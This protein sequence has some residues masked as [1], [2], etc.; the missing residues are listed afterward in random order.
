[1]VFASLFSL[2]IQDPVLVFAVI[3]LVILFSPLL[4]NRLRVPGILGLILSGV[5]LGPH[6]LGVLER[7]ES[8]VLFS[9]IGLLYIMF[10]AGLEMDMDDFREN[11]NKSIVFGVLTFIIPL[12]LGWLGSYYVLGYS[13]LSSFLLASMFST[14]TLVAYPIIGRLGITQNK[15]V[16][17]ILGGTIITDAAVLI[18]LAVVTNLQKPDISSLF[19][20]QFVVSLVVFVFVVLWGVPRL[21]RWF[22]RQ[23]EGEGNSQY[24]FVL[25]VVFLSGFLAHV[26]GAEPI[27]GAFLA[28]LALNQLIPKA[29]PLM[30]RTEFVGNTLFIPFFLLSVGMLVDVRVL[31]EGPEALFVAGVIICISFLGKWLAAYATQKIY[32]MKAA[33]R[34]LIFGM[35][36]GHAAATIAVVLIGYN[37]RILDERA[38]N[39]TVILILIS[40]LVSSIVA[41]KAGREIAIAEADKVPEGTEGDERILIPVENMEHL[42]RL[43]D[44]SL[45]I[46]N[47]RSVEPLMPLVVVSEHHAPD[48][49]IKLHQKKVSSVINEV[50]EHAELM[51]PVYRVDL[52]VGNGIIRAVQELRITEI[53]MAW[54]GKLSAREWF[55][56][57]ILNRVVNHTTVQTLFCKFCDPLNTIQT[58]IVVVPRNSEREAGFPFWVNTILQ[59]AKGAGARI[60]ILGAR[61]TL[62]TLEGF[63]ESQDRYTVNISYELFDDW[64][65]FPELAKEVTKNDLLTVV[66]GRPHT[67]SYR[68]EFNVVPRY[69]SR[70]FEDV[71]YVILYPEQK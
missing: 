41:E 39:G 59:F 56:G 61:G 46:K 21:S 4:F 32:G 54:N 38:L 6:G 55:M 23:L 19:W 49:K 71:S 64:D 9:T 62:S 24:L 16:T 22:F 52:N 42:K 68:P 30:H 35:S 70:Y 25:A 34:R 40:C 69:L 2:P 26:A 63:V 29:S 50:T 43:L 67:V 33:E 15:T 12:V 37:L 28:G 1:M 5:L 57:N 10:L 66:L 53:V 60:R 17:L 8:V 14:H 18:I 58:I 48:D 65:K 13:P 51:L 11:K 20:V 44:F 3:L 36:S 31:L 27:I 7:D 47:P 45:L